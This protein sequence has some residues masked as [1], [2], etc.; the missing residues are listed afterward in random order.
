MSAKTKPTTRNF[1]LVVLGLL[2]TIGLI[3]G[4]VYWLNDQGLISAGGGGERP[5]GGPPS[6]F[7]EREAGE[8][9]FSGDQHEAGG[10][11]S[12]AIAGVFKT[13]LQLAVVVLI[14]AG[15]RKLYHAISNRVRGPGQ[16]RTTG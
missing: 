6:G 3:S 2:L 10:F 13:L 4:G 14:V 12:R 1:W 7:E 15:G 5:E 11:D 8:R 9:P 16:A